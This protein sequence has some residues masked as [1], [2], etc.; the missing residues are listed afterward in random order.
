MLKTTVDSNFN[1]VHSRHAGW[2]A[3]VAA[4]PQGT[5]FHTAAIIRAWEATPGLE[6]LSLAAVNASGEILAMLVSVQVKTLNAIPSM[7]SRAIQFATPLRVCGHG[8]EA[9]L[10]E[11]IRLHDEHMRSRSL[12]VE[13]RCVHPPA[14]E[15]TPLL[16]SGYTL[17]DYINYEVDL[18]R[19]E[20]ELWKSVDKGMRQKINSSFRKGVEIVDDESPAGVAR[21]YTLLEE[22]YRRARVPLAAFELFEAVLKHLPP[23]SVRI[24]T[25][26]YKQHPVASII[27]LIHAGRIFSWYGGTQR[28][29]GL[30]PFAC[31]V[32]DDIRWG[33]EHGLSVYDF[34][35]AGWPNEAYGPRRFKASF[36]G[37][38]VRYGRYRATYS[39]I[40]LRLAELAYRAS[41]SIGVWSGSRKHRAP[42]PRDDATSTPIAPKSSTGSRP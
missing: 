25:A 11:L 4:H 6:P 31:I 38:E 1:V 19:S 28:I 15:K 34:G 23:E 20:E 24:R 14:C 35:G 17:C 26:V 10:S 21:M 29:P 37:S 42:A 3:F 12:F 22:S 30:S 18:S 7:S 2:D 13:V 9:A 5:I 39:P 40:R 33:C 36:G 16:K 41:Q 32:W 8:G 27:S